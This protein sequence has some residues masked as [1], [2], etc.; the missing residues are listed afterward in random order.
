LVISGTETTHQLLPWAFAGGGNV[1][2]APNVE[3]GAELRYWLYRQYRSQRIEGVPFLGTL[4]IAK[5]YHDSWETSGGV[6]VHD[7][8]AAPALELMAGVQYDRSPAPPETVTL[9]QPSFTHWAV[10]SGLRYRLGRVRLGASYVHYWYDVP[11]ITNSLTTPPTN[12]RGSGGN[13]IITTS[14]EIAL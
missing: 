5:N 6:R 3:V 1:D 9:D 4:E 11:T 10:H 7:L 14:I 8:A 2:V 13:H 12:A